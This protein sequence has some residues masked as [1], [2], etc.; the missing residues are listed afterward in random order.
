MR[1]AYLF[2]FFILFL[3]PVI[4]CRKST[5]PGVIPPMPKPAFTDAVPIT[6][7]PSPGEQIVFIIEKANTGKDKEAEALVM[8]T[9]EMDAEAILVK[10]PA[11]WLAKD[12]IAFWR[13]LTKNKT[14]IKT[15]ILNEKITLNFSIVWF[16]LTYK[17]GSIKEMETEL[18]FMDGKWYMM[19]DQ[20]MLK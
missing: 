12:K 20:T 1:K 19:V 14:V 7:K 2:I 6:D 11:D 18:H 13:L 16:R 10:Q 17:D 9:I 15:E 4:S 5:A 3:A 8:Y